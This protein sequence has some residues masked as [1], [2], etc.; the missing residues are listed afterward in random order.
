MSVYKNDKPEWLE[1]SVLSMVNQTIKPDEI[2][3]IIDGEIPAELQAKID[4]IKVNYPIVKV[5]QTET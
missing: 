2:I 3:L 4:E 5:Y 1:I